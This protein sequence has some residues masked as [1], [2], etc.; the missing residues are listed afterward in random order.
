[1]LALSDYRIAYQFGT[2][3]RVPIREPQR[4]RAGHV[5]V[6]ESFQARTKCPPDRRRLLRLLH[7]AK[8]SLDRLEEH[9]GCPFCRIGSLAAQFDEPALPAHRFPSRNRTASWRFHAKNGRNR[10]VQSSARIFH[11]AIVSYLLV[12]RDGFE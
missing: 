10:R 5:A 2:T 8:T 1:M 7:P 6:F 12:T 11:F 4:E 9:A 3:A